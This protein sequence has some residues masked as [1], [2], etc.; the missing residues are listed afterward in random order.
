MADGVQFKYL[1]APLSQAQLEQPFQI[2]PP[3][4]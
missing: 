4:D 1:A 2:P 3:L